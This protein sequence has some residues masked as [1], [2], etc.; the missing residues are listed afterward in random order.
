MSDWSSLHIDGYELGMAQNHADP[1]A[2]SLF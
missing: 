2:L 1:D